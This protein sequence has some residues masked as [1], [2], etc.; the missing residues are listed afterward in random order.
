MSWHH[1]GASGSAARGA[2]WRWEW[3]PERER[4]QNKQTLQGR[5]RHHSEW[6]CKQC[7]KCNF[8]DRSTCRLFGKQRQEE[9]TVIAGETD[10]P[11]PGTQPAPKRAPYNSSRTAGGSGSGDHAALKKA[12]A[13]LT[14]AQDAD[15]PQNFIDELAQQR[16]VPRQ[17]GRERARYQEAEAACWSMHSKR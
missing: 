1:A 8:I 11:L 6:E 16:N 13:A 17:L 3:T 15:L 10:E 5:V 14:A 12:E 4:R 2:L 7:G 9:D